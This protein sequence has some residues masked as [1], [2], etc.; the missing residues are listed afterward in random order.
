MRNL[1]YLG[2]YR[3]TEILNMAPGSLVIVNPDNTQVDVDSF[4]DKLEQREA[5]R[6]EVHND[7]N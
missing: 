4:I 7:K 2:R 5:E 6:R 3:N 1:S